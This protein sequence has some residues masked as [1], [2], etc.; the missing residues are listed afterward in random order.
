MKYYRYIPIHTNR[1]NPFQYRQH[2]SMA[3]A[4]TDRL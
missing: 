2:S 4:Q 3:N 1:S